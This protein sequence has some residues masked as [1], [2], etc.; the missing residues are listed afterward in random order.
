MTGDSLTSI[1]RAQ[2][3]ASRQWLAWL[4]RMRY[5]WLQ[6]TALLG[7]LL[8]LILG[9]MVVV[10]LVYLVATTVNGS[11]LAVWQQVLLSELAP[12]LFWRPLMN[13]L[14][15]GVL[16]ALGTVIL[17][18]YLAWLVVMTD[19]PGRA[20]IGLLASIPFALP[21]FAIAL[22]WETIF[23]NDRIGGQAGLLFDL[24]INVPDWLAWG[25]V[26]IVLTLIA[27]YF[28]LAFL[29]ISAALASVNTELL[30]A[31][32]M[33]GATR[34]RVLRDITLPVVF[35]A[36]L[37]SGLLAFAEGV[38]NFASPALLGLP[39]R[40]HTISTR[41]YG[42]IQTGQTERGFVLTI[43]L[44]VIAAVVLWSSTRIVSSRRSYTTITGKG[45]RRR[46]Q[47]LRALRWPAFGVALAIC[48]ATTIV[49]GL[50][51]LLSS[52]AQ[53]TGSLSGGLTT[54]YWFGESNPSFAQGQP[55]IFH[56]EQIIEATWNTLLLG[57]LVALVATLL[58]LMIGYVVVRGRN[59]SISSAV[60]LL[61]YLPFLIPG[62]A[63]G[64]VYIAQF[65]RPIG[66]F[67]A[68]YGTF[69]LLVIAGAAATLPFA[70]QSGRSAMSQVAGELEE[71]ATMIGA[72]FVRRLGRIFLPL[73]IRGLLAGA[74]LVFVNMTRDLSLVVLLVTPTTPLL[75]VL[76]FRYASEGFAQFAY[77]ITMI[78]A[79][80]SVTA[81]ILAR[82]A[83]G[84]AQPWNER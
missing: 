84:L 48:M 80:I 43:L 13:T 57:L 32:E 29:L 61:S 14:A 21:T 60:G 46:R 6:P 53:R 50:A 42:S 58:G 49:P 34:A 4:N 78:I 68:L 79:I 18:G 76:A 8:L 38:S 75:S 16:V 17:G 11:G 40:F 82:R 64:A 5:Q 81:T 59:R 3:R 44:I 54:H 66:P 41:L 71:A 12:N 83:Q 22:A 9:A 23:R 69:A 20:F 52:F 28:S 73:T 33:T 39:V 70:A 27:H 65:G 25:F 2:A 45:A 51:L 56:N 37:S 19:V 30:E 7:L 74:V 67:P 62:V 10:P 26:P 31:A 72:N 47:R 63:L 35:P 24:G 77:A 15:I 36:I 1:D 55:G